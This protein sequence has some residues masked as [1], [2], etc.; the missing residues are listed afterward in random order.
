MTFGFSRGIGAV[1][2]KARSG[3]LTYITEYKTVDEA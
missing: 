1:S 2:Y 3:R